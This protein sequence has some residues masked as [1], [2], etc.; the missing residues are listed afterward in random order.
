[1]RIEEIIPV[2]V[3]FIPKDIETGKLYISKKFQVAIHLCACGCRGKT[4]TPLNEW[5]LTENNNQVSLSPSI[6]N[7]SGE[8]PYHAHYYITYNKIKWC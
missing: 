6:G 8:I 3:E 2:F 5:K 4:V 1:M 7:W